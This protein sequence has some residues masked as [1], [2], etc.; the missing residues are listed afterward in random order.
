MMTRPSESANGCDKHAMEKKRP[1]INPRKNGSLV[2]KVVYALSKKNKIVIPSI[3][4]GIPNLKNKGSKMMVAKPIVTDILLNFNLRS[5]K[6]NVIADKKIVSALRNLT[7][8]KVCGKIFK[9][10]AEFSI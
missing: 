3:R 9:N 4:A 5:K 1:E 2:V 10:R 8:D 7:V 6:R